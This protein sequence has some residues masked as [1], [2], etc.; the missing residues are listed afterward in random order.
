MKKIAL[1]GRPNVGKSSLLNALLGYRRAIVFDK[2]GTTLDLV[3]EKVKWGNL[4][5]VDSQGIFGEGDTEVLE[6][7]LNEADAFLFVVDAQAGLTPFDEWI[8]SHIKRSKKPALLVLNKSDSGN[9]HAEE[10]FAKLGIEEM[11]PT[12]ASHRRGLENLKS[13]CISQASVEEETE[14]EEPIKLA[15]VGRPNSGKSTLMNKLCRKKVSRVSP[16]PLTTRDPV[17]Y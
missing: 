11:V 16:E 3:V 15:L 10:Y 4:Q 7:V 17:S 6:K 1:I 8:G 14:K 13:W 5:L 12:S 9:I 2:P